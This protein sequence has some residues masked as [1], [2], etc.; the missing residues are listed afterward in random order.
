MDYRRRL[1]DREEVATQEMA[2]AYTVAM[3]PVMNRLKRITAQIEEM[4]ANGEEPDAIML[5]VQS[6]LQQNILTLREG[7]KEWKDKSVV[8]VSNGQRDSAMLANTQK[9]VVDLIQGT[10]PP[11]VV[12]SWNPINEEAIQAL[13][14]YSGDGSPLADLF[15]SVVS[16]HENGIRDSLIAGTAA[17]L[18]PEALAGVMYSRVADPTNLSMTRARVIARTEMMRASRAANQMLFADNP[19]I[20]GYRRMA[21]QDSRACIACIGLSGTFHKVG[22]IMATHPQCRCSQVPVT[23]SF[24][25]IVGDKTIPDHNPPPLTGEMIMSGLTEADHRA[26]LGDVRYEQWKN[27]TKLDKFFTIE[28]DPEWGPTTRIKPIWDTQSR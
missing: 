23:R 28:N 13:V 5:M 24:A 8:A 20:I 18:G 17:G 7:L 25:E 22:D 19:G 14:G 6:Q 27:G 11:G 16:A 4:K 26:I 12:V 15:D 21:I 10:P 1:A 9:Q 2:Q 3:V